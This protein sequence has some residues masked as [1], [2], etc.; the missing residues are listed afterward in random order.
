MDLA[1]SKGD[2]TPQL[3]STWLSRVI[4]KMECERELSMFM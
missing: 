3:M 1:L 4:V 2:F